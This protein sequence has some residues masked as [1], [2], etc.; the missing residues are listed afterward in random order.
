MYSLKP[1][2]LELPYWII[3]V[4]MWNIVDF[5]IMH[6]AST[7]LSSGSVDSVSRLQPSLKQKSF[8]LWLSAVTVLLDRVF[9]LIA[10]FDHHSTVDQLLQPNFILV[11]NFFT[12]AEVS[13]LGITRF[14]V[15]CTCLQQSIDRIPAGFVLTY[16]QCHCTSEFSFLLLSSQFIQT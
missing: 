4:C 6:L 5:S 11:I 14:L 16:L 3:T 2:N 15:L 10:E 9:D 7:Y 13:K 8:D 12:S 1:P